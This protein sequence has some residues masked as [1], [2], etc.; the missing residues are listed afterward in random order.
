MCSHILLIRRANDLTG[1]QRE[2][3]IAHFVM[4]ITSA[5]FV[6][7]HP[8]VRR[9]CPAIKNNSCDFP[10]ELRDR[11]YEAQLPAAYPVHPEL[12]RILQTDWGAL[13]KDARSAQDDGADRLHAPT[14]SELSTLTKAITASGIREPPGRG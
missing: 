7:R 14:L 10:T 9:T 3:Q 2:S 8:P 11:A 6:F 13:E 1:S 5:E 4:A 12:F